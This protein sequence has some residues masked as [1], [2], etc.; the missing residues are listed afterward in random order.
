MTIYFLG[1]IDEGGESFHHNFFSIHI[2]IHHT[3]TL[4]EGWIMA[5]ERYAEVFIPHTCECKFTWK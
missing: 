3:W 1:I 2:G 5:P 4:V